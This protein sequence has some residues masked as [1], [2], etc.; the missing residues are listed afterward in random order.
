MNTPKTLL[1]LVEGAR[2]STPADGFNDLVALQG[3]LNPATAKRVYEVLKAIEQPLSAYID[4]VELDEE[5]AHL[6][7]VFDER[8][9]EPV[10]LLEWSPEIKK[11]H[12]QREELT[13]VLRLLD[14][15]GE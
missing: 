9:T 6:R 7:K 1:E 15:Q 10:G 12:A 14:G 2:K 11:L 3:R 13:A 5:E 8:R 4:D